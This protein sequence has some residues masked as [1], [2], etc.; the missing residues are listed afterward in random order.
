VVDAADP[1]KRG[2]QYLAS[3]IRNL[4]GTR[5][6]GFVLEHAPSE[7]KWPA[8]KYRLQRTDGSD[9]P[10]VPDRPLEPAWVQEA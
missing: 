7:G 5:A 4:A 10:I 9:A 6:A 8:D 1:L 3:R 2:R